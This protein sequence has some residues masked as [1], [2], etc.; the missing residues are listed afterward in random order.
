MICSANE[1]LSSIEQWHALNLT[2]N[3]RA[4]QPE[5][6]GFEP[7]WYKTIHI[8]LSQYIYVYMT[9]VILYIWILYM[10]C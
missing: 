2:A 8:M 9:N 3:Y 7:Q 10:K 1:S 6:C 4:V 5:G